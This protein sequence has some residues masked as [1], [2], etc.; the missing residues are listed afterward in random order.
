MYLCKHKLLSEFA[1]IEVLDMSVICFPDAIAVNA[2]YAMGM[3]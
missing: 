3:S 1:L 2:V